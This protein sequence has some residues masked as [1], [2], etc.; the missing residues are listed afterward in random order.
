M[1]FM[2][3][4]KV[5]EIFF[6]IKVGNARCKEPVP[7]VFNLY[8]DNHRWTVY[9]YYFKTILYDCFIEIEKAHGN[10][11]TTGLGLGIIELCLANKP[12]VN[13]IRIF[14][15]YQSVVDLF[16]TFAENAKLKL[17]KIE[18]II[19]DANELKNQRSDCLLLDHFES[20]TFEEIVS[21]ARHLA[22]NNLQDFIYFWP[23]TK[24]FCEQSVKNKLPILVESFTNWG[25]SLD[26][27]NFPPS[28]D[29]RLLKFMQV[30]ANFDRQ[31]IK[32]YYQKKYF[33]QDLVIE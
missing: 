32:N 13:K 8:V 18:I 1:T 4:Y 20:E 2:D 33:N 14:E 22:Q 11:I 12:N 24:E 19:E 26:I 17:D 23:A 7:G 9:D 31:N 21:S 30:Y 15:K 28:V 27:K 16:L 29:N 5:P 3:N 10:C 6:P 25:E